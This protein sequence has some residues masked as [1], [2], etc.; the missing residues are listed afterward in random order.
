MRG[1]PQVS[2]ACD[3]IA[4]VLLYGVSHSNHTGHNPVDLHGNGGRATLLGLRERIRQ[5]TKVPGGAADADKAVVDTRGSALAWKILKAGRFGDI[6]GGLNNRLC[7]RV[8]GA[9]L[10]TGSQAQHL[11]GFVA[12]T[13]Q[14]LGHTH[15][16]GSHRAG[17]IHHHRVHLASRF[18]HLRAL[19][20]QPHL[21]ATAG[22]HQDRR[23]RGQAQRARA[24]DDQHRHRSRERVLHR[25]ANQQVSHQRDQGN[26]NNRRHKHLRDPVHEALHRRLASL[27]VLD[28]LPHLRQR[29]LR[30]NAGGLHHQSPRRVQGRAGDHR[31]L[32]DLH[33][34]GLAG[35]HGFVDS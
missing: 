32:A 10:H 6:V 15:L 20:Q 26:H 35:Q 27:R 30:P 9:S 7:D 25:M 29:R 16:A 8:L 5:G 12:R 1:H 3:G 24:R 11:L 19:N 4:R 21:G 34:D 23:R 28:Q 2:Q 22:T 18:E 13:R 14:H 31:A 33:R 17:L